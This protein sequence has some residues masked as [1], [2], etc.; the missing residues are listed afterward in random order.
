MNR[1]ELSLWLLFKESFLLSAFTFGG[2]FVIISLMKKKFVDH[3][4]WI[5]EREMLDMIAIAQSAPGVI[6]V[7]AA[8]IIG[9][10]LAGFKGIGVTLLGTILPPFLV[11]TLVANSYDVL[12]QYPYVQIALLGM[13]AGVGAI[14]LDVVLSLIQGLIK[15]KA[16]VWMG[17]MAIAFFA[18]ILF[19]VHILWI[20]GGSALLG[21]LSLS[22]VRLGIQL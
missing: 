15:D 4:Q 19:N 3:Y 22:L 21:L 9:H 8:I 18:L 7:N 17:V 14:L 1:K 5:Q 11:I 2:G 20:I 16:W 10:Q 6:A 12:V 13:Q